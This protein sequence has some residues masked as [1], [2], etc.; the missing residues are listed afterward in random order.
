MSELI[1]WTASEIE[2]FDD[3][4]LELAEKFKSNNEVNNG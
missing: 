3:V 1:K 4:R 2:E